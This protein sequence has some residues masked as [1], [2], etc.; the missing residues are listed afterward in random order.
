MIPNIFLDERKIARMG[1]G[2]AFSAAI[3]EGSPLLCE[4]YHSCSEI[5]LN[6]FFK[7]EILTSIIDKLAFVYYFCIVLLNPNLVI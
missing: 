6:N 1:T 7:L 3:P 5:C 4:R 2:K